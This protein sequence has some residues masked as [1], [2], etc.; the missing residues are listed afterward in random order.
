MLDAAQI[1]K[2]Y[3]AL[4]NVFIDKDAAY[5]MISTEV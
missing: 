5:S 3:A 2:I 4:S 1:D